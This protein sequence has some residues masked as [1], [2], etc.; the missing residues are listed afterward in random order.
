[1]VDHEGSYL[2][3][4]A[5]PCRR[6]PDLFRTAFREIRNTLQGTPQRVVRR[7]EQREDSETGS[8][9]HHCGLSI[10]R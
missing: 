9:L 8:W 3:A 2:V 1:M 6:R 5:T 10:I 7:I 4:G